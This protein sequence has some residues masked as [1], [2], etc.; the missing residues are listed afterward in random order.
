VQQAQT[1]KEV[2]TL[3]A[4]ISGVDNLQSPA[5]DDGEAL[6]LGKK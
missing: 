2:K 4:E 5:D 6:E 3:P 1:T